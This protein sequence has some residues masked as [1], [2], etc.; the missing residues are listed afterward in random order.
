MLA[1]LLLL[2]AEAHAQLRLEVFA[3]GFAQPVAFVQD[4]VDPAVQYVVEQ[5]GRVRVLQDGTLLPDDFLDLTSSV[6]TSGERGLLGLAFAPDYASSGRFYANFTNTSG[7]TVIARFHRSIDPLVADAT[8]RFDLVWGGPGGPS[9][10]AQ[11]AGN[12][13]GGHLAFGPDGFLYIGLGDGGSG[14]DPG[15]RAQDPST[16]LGKMLRIDVSVPDTHPT[17]YAV[18]PDNPFVAGGPV[19]ALPEIWSFGLRNPWRYGFDD[20]ARG[21]TG[22]LLLADVGQGS[23]EEVDYEPPGAGGRNY[24]WRNREGAHDNVVSLPPAYLPLTEPIHEYDHGTG[25]SITGGQVYRGIH[26]GPAHQGRYFFADFITGR[27]WS[28]AL[29]ID[30]TTAEATAFDVREH[31]SELE[32]STPITNVSSFG[33]DADGELYLVDYSS[34]RILKIAPPACGV[35]LSSSHA[36]FTSQPAGS[37][38]DVTTAPVDC[39]WSA[40]TTASWIAIT[41]GTGVGPGTFSYTVAANVSATLRSGTIAVAQQTFTVTQAGTVL[42][43]PFGFID[44]PADG[45]S[46]VTGAI[47][48]TG[49]ALDDLGIVHLRLYRD[50]VPPE[51]G[52]LVFIGDATRVSGARPDVAIVYP[53]Y[54]DYNEAGWGYALL[55]NLLPNQ[56]NGSYTFHVYAEDVDGHATLLGSRT[57]TCTNATATLPFGTIDTPAQGATISG[58]AFVNFGWALTPPPKTIPLDGSTIQV[59]IDG[60][61]VG[62]VTYNNFRSDIPTVFPGY[63]NSNGAVGYR[64]LDTTTLANGVHTIA[65]SVVDD[66][67]AAEGIGSR[68]FTV[69]NAG[70]T[71]QAEP[72]TTFAPVALVRSATLEVSPGSVRMRQGMNAEAPWEV[73][74]AD[75]SGARLVAL[76]EFGRLELD[77]GRDRAGRYEGALR[78]GDTWRPLPVGSQ[79]DPATGTFLWQPG[80]GFVGT[81]RLVFARVD[82]A[83]RVTR[84]PVTVVIR[85]TQASPGRVLAAID[86]PTGG[87]ATLP[88]VVTGWALDESAWAGTGIDAVHVWA[89]PETGGSP[90]FLGAATLDA[91][92]PDVGAAFGEQFGPSGYRLRVGWLPPAAYLLAVF[93]HSA[94][95][96]QFATASVVRVVVR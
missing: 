70:S 79:L 87:E 53:G 19:P 69:Q 58:T 30:P 29:A 47:G 16:L 49:W 84:V 75:S 23:W 51:T 94:V 5:G 14:N 72:Q 95:T 86:A 22:A 44:T 67:G 59:W 13:N 12:H 40:S 81:Y 54:P 83:D 7:D 2:A 35:N 74:P 55:T 36:S 8:S 9:F 48:V 6:S 20:P 10:I 17:G 28:L 25:R 90:Q 39:A 71:A 80:P 62:D 43:P 3:S 88:L 37:S 46:G 33:V 1:G 15:H 42:S 34:G 50:P 91:A 63:A 64:H 32:A 52:G 82:P 27:V 93:P 68:Y 89:Y 85:P 26:L 56:G 78:V 66:M 92:R 41:A 45:A 31:T 96:G 24:G 38:V 57:I 65:W 77:L 4:P 73:M 21:G 60:A 76:P 11:P 18:P 61:P